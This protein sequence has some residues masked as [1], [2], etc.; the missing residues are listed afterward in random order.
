[1]KLRELFENIY[2]DPKAQEVAII[3]GRFN[4]PHQGHKAAWELA[5]EYE[6]WYVGTNKSTVGPKDPLPF[7]VKIAAMKA[8]WPEV[9]DHLVAEQS[10]WTL[11]TKVYNEFG[12]VT[13]H[14]VT[15][16]NDARVFVAGLQKSNGIEG[17][18]GFYRFKDIV[19][20]ESPRIS[21][22]TDLRAAVANNDKEAFEQ[23]AGVSADTP[24]AGH[25]FFDVVKHYLTPYLQQAANKEAEKAEKERLKAEKEKAKLAKKKEPEVAEG[26]FGLSAKEKGAIMNVASKISDIPGNWDFEKDAFSDQGIENLKNVLKNEKYVKYALNLTSKDYDADLG[27]EAAGVGIITKQNTTA[28]VNVSTPGKNLRAF[29]LAEEI[30]KLEQELQEATEKHITKRQ[31]QSTTGLNTFSDGERWNGDYVSYRLGMAAASTDGK[32]DPNMDAKSWIGKQKSTHPYTKEEQE[33][34]KK[35]YKAVGAKYKDLNHGDMRS[36]EL[37]E[38]NK[39][40]PVAKRKKNKYGV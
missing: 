26:L 12:P 13:L 40:S 7:N 6:Q 22:A 3:F 38:I 32:I 35:A 15:D 10:W 14:V 25:A 39:V 28:D 34:L 17:A 19:W 11:A 33:I 23:A 21:S 9:A 4:P 37:D 5:S 27:E 30:A 18:H 29:K 16:A 31:Q 36:L 8:I 2:E 20:V 24:V 1:M